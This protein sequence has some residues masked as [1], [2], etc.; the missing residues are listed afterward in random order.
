MMLFRL[1]NTQHFGLHD[2]KRRSLDEYG[3]AA[4]S[5]RPERKSTTSTS[6]WNR[7]PDVP[8]VHRHTTQSQ[9]LLTRQA[10]PIPSLVLDH[11]NVT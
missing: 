8:H 3:I 4:R 5:R 2:T 11:C 7:Y 9:P 1:H 6:A 10:A